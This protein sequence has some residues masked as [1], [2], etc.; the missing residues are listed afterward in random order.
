M[1]S[2]HQIFVYLYYFLLLHAIHTS[3]NNTIIELFYLDESI[4]IMVYNM[5]S[6]E[7]LIIESSKIGE[8]QLNIKVVWTITFI[9]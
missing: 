1:L 2:S 4:S 9:R 6:L 5:T 8:I 3:D 7:V